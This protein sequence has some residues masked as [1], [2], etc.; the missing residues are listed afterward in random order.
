MM[1]YLILS[2]LVFLG[3]FCGLA[4]GK[5]AQEELEP[6]R[7]YLKWLM[8]IIFVAVLAIFLYLNQSIA[9]LLTIPVIIILFSFSK[10]YETLWYY[11]LA[12]IMFISYNYNGFSIIAPLIFLYGFPLGSLLLSENTKGSWKKILS[13]IILRYGWF[14]LLSICFQLLQLVL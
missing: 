3:A 1:Q 11:A 13:L 9:F 10:R 4:V 7:A 14:L 2:V 12:P 6:G 5:I 8:H